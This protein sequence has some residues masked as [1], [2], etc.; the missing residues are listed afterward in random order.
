M[1]LTA[2]LFDAL[3]LIGGK[4]HT[5]VPGE[6][7]RE[8]TIV[9]ENGRITSIGKPTSTPADAR[10][11]DLHGMHVIP[12]LIDGFAYHDAE[13][14]WLYTAAGVTLIR[15][16]GNDLSRIFE[17]RDTLKR[18]AATGPALSIS[19]AVF[20]G[21][22]PATS[23][24]I[25]LRN[26]DDARASLERLAME[27]IDFVA[28]QSNVGADAWKALLAA[29]A[30]K[31]L[32]VWGPLPK[33]VALADALKEGQSGF[34]FLDCLLPAGKTWETVEIAQLEPQVKQFAA[35]GARITP[36]LR[37]HARL[38]EQPDDGAP[39]LAQLG[40]QYSNL[41]RIDAI[42]RKK[43][44]DEAARKKIEAQLGKQRAVLGMLFHAGAKLVPG[45]GAPHPWLMP[46]DGLHRE[47]REWQSDGI[48]A[49]DLLRLATADAA[50]ALGIEAD[51]GTLAPGKIADIVVLRADPTAD[52]AALDAIE[53]VV[54]R[55]V[56]L[57][58]EQLDAK[59]AK[60]ASIQSAA[61]AAAQ[62]PIEV[63]APEL[64]EGAQ[65]LSGLT[66]TTSALGVLA[67]ERWAIVREVDGT[68]TFCG[69]R[70]T[71]GG[72]T[73]AERTVDVRQRVRDNKFDSFEMRVTS[74]SHELLVRGN[75]VAEQWRVERRGDGKFL[76]VKAATDHIVA[77]D[78]GSVTT[79]MLLAHMRG[80]GAFPILRF[81]EGLE[82]EVV[83][84][85]LRLDS[86]GGH[87]FRT[88][89]GGKLAGFN[90]DGSLKIVVEQQGSGG[91]QTESM[92]I[93]VHGTQGLP[94]P[95]D[96]LALMRTKPAE[97][98]TPTKK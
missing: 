12:G 72:P 88:P 97:A 35:S 94:L 57:T 66:Q 41:W 18:D 25:P 74:G 58:R 46:G 2:L 15:D 27:Q 20:D 86:G 48:P 73:I 30:T 6:A 45:S 85:E 51:R 24:A 87:Q 67:A 3:V 14:D 7:P 60:L 71:R 13:H 63:A 98:S 75:F 36:V 49:A 28:F 1:F 89:D 56:A 44:I 79:L 91:T 37:A 29:S 82:L 62:E 26:A 64:P 52:I 42:Q 77:V 68:L 8:A 65:L 19:G 92:A 10:T 70:R 38:L 78:A 96:K 83:R 81:D 34:V 9:I 39:E 69:K 55:G 23:A 4:V 95:A 93:D 84:W 22:P 33:E 54:L 59:L 11:I 32:Q 80:E 40:P 17:S 50:S 21:I 90:E 16:H 61:R 5:M 43:N 31:K 76:D 53:T 47:L